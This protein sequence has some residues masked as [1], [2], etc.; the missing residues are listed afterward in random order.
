MTSA[1]EFRR[2]FN[3][4]PDPLAK[5]RADIEAAIQDALKYRRTAFSVPVSDK[6]PAGAEIPLIE[7][8]RERWGWE[9]T[10]SHFRNEHTIGFVLPPKK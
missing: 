9:V 1:E 8:Y 4:K 2:L 3:E 10:S 5:L 7:E 6:L